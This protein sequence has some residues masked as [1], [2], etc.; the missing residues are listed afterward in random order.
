MSVVY[1]FIVCRRL[2]TVWE[3]PRTLRFSTSAGESF[4][5]KGIR[6]LLR[7]VLRYSQQIVA[8]GWLVKG[9]LA[10]VCA[11]TRA[12]L[13]M[14]RERHLLFCDYSQRSPLEGFQAKTHYRIFRR[15]CSVDHYQ[16]RNTLRRSDMS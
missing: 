8:L 1:R 4:F 6:R 14:P 3:I 16:F 15:F 5:A 12:F 9:P 11:E 13:I 10:R 7:R 2:K